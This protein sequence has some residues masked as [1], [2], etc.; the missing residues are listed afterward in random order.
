MRT[1]LL[2]FLALC[3]SAW[4]SQAEELL[5]IASPTVPISSLT[6]EQISEIYLLKSSSWSDGGRIIPVNRET[7]SETRSRFNSTVLKQDN[8]ELAAYWNQMHFKGKMPPVIQESDQ[9]MV[10]FVQKVPGA[11]GYVAA[12]TPVGNAKVIGRVP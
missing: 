6:H 9:A 3:A 4:A 11:I 10:A 1:L 5:I 8:A 12:S 7:A 2:L